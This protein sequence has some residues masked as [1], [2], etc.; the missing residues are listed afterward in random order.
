MRKTREREEDMCSAV[1]LLDPAPDPGACPGQG[2]AAMFPPARV[3]VG[4]KKNREDLKRRDG[5]TL[6]H[7][8]AVKKSGM[9]AQKAHRDTELTKHAGAFAFLKMGAHARTHTHTLIV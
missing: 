3:C 8:A 7:Y 6:E 5:A 4:S 9:K 2:G 1:S